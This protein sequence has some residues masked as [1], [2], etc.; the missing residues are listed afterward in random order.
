MGSA[1]VS[2]SVRYRTELRRPSMY[3]LVK[4]KSWPRGIGERAMKLLLRQ[5]QNNVLLIVGISMVLFWFLG[6]GSSNML[7]GFLYVAL[8]LGFIF[9]VVSLVTRFR[10]P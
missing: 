2:G 8:L 7:G 1:K 3:S 5:R 9:V 10:G 6:F 4:P